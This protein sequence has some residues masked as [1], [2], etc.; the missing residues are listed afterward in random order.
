MS[1]AESKVEVE[2]SEKKII[3]KNIAQK[4]HFLFYQTQHSDSKNRAQKDSCEYMFICPWCQVELPMSHTNQW[5]TSYE[6]SF[7]YTCPWN[8]IY[9]MSE[10]ESEKV[11][12]TRP[13][14]TTLVFQW[15]NV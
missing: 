3:N 1:H 13:S 11:T 4:L 15:K 8:I 5:C 12:I 14:S 9:S 6:F 2:K 10:Q 7:L